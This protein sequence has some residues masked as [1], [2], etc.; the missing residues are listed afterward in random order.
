MGGAMGVRG[1]DARRAAP[2]P[3]P[4]RAA[5]HT[6]RPTRCRARMPP[7]PLVHHQHQSGDSSAVLFWGGGLRTHAGC[8]R[9]LARAQCPPPAERAWH[10]FVA[11]CCL[12]PGTAHVLIW[13]AQQH[14]HTRMDVRMGR[15]VSELAAFAR[16]WA[17]RR[18]R[19]PL[20]LPLW[21][22]PRSRAPCPRGPPTHTERQCER[23]ASVRRSIRASLP[24]PRH[25]PSLGSALGCRSHAR[26]RSGGRRGPRYA[27]AGA[28]GGHSLLRRVER[29]GA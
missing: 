23:R 21:E 10:H 17:L 9:K 19:A 29:L 24:S 2:S 6:H 26:C 3:P 12:A 8:A 13:A 5:L 11:P 28:A 16:T 4:A 1:K 20:H 27:G 7:A 25:G 22:T 18:R 15:R 14:A